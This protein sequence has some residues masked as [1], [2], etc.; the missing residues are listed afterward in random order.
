MKKIVNGVEIEMTSEEVE[1]F[2]AFLKSD[3]EENKER[4]LT[5]FRYERNRRLAASDWTQGRD[6]NLSNDDEW[7]SYR[8]ALRDLPA[9]TDPANPTWPTEPSQ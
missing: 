8:T 6:V 7:K 2:E 9:T 4:E 5:L 1:A 3:E